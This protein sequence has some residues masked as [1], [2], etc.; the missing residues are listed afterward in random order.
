MC[1]KKA[2]DLCVLNRELVLVGKSELSLGWANTFP[3]LLFLICN[4]S[5]IDVK[6]S[7]GERRSK[8]IKND[9][10]KL[11]KIKHRVAYLEQFRGQEERHHSQY[12]RQFQQDCA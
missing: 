9:H 12:N 11:Y 1:C 7:V 3:L 10:I 5:V 4:Y 8:M 2:K 6:K